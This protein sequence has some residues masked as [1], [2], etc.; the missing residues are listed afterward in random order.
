MQRAELTLGPFDEL[1]EALRVHLAQVL[2]STERF[3]AS[4]KSL[5]ELHVAYIAWRSRVPR[6]IPREV[7]LSRELEASSVTADYL[8]EL[9]TVASE[10]RR[11][12]DLRPR[13]SRAVENP[14]ADCAPFEGTRKERR[15]ASLRYE[16]GVDRLLASWGLHHLHLSSVIEADGYCE[17][18]DVVL[19][20]GFRQGSAYLVDLVR[21]GGENANWASAGIFKIL[22]RNWPNAGFAT[23]L[24]EGWK[25]K[26]T[27]SDDDRRRLRRAGAIDG[28]VEVDGRLWHPVSAMTGAGT[29]LEAAM[30]SGRLDAFLRGAGV[31]TEEDLRG[32]LRRAQESR[33][34]DDVWTPAVNGEEYGFVNGEWFA[35]LGS[36]MPDY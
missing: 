9:V 33:G 15:R 29:P 1:R 8:Q 16:R 3:D 4:N 23:Q 27:W 11:G 19:L 12:V 14:P 32:Y 5:R 10:I 21:H 30:F 18:D 13:L 17:R 6:T 36:L 7:H 24:P 22:V 2:G 20:V 34:L 26:R 28:P 31:A 35:P 25:L